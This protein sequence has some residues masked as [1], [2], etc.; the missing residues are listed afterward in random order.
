MSLENVNWCQGDAK[1]KK[2]PYRMY[3]QQE[4]LRLKKLLRFSQ[5]VC[6]DGSAKNLRG[7]AVLLMRKRDFNTVGVLGRSHPMISQALLSVPEHPIRVLNP[8]KSRHADRTAPR[9]RPTM[10]HGTFL[11]STRRKHGQ[12]HHVPT[13]PSQ[14][15]LQCNFRSDAWP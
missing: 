3:E 4:A 9:Q 2:R 13:L 8:R 14:T 7:D 12:P 15:T 5:A 11:K 10:G 1:S 6:M